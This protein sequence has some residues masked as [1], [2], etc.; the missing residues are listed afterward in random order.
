MTFVDFIDTLKQ[1]KRIPLALM[2]FIGLYLLINMMIACSYFFQGA[3]PDTKLA[4]I[5]TD[6][7]VNFDQ[8]H[9]FGFYLSDYDDLPETQLQLTLEGTA[10]DPSDKSAS[11]AIIGAPSQ[12]SK[13][14]HIGQGIP[15]GAT[16]HAIEKNRVI[17]NDNGELERLSMPIPK[18]KQ[19]PVI[20][21]LPMNSGLRPG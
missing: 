11:L 5:T 18:L 8:Q 21:G 15:D 6:R 3:G 13:A 7:S 17:I 12:E 2:G 19:V 16:I 9:L 20:P 1:D 4:S 14:Y 10:I